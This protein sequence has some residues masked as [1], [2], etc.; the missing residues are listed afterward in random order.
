MGSA[1]AGWRA[2]PA[3]SLEIACKCQ[4]TGRPPDCGGAG[5]SITCTGLVTRRQM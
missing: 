3:A 5:G 1:L 2:L 4:R